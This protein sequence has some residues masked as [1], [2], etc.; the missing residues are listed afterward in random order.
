MARLTLPAVLSSVDRVRS[1]LQESLAPLEPR[2]DDFFKIEL[3]VVEL[4]VNIS[5]Y[6]YPDGA[7][8]ME[9]EIETR[10]PDGDGHDHRRGD[11]LRSPL[12]PQARRELDPGHGPDGRAGHLPGPDP[13]G[14]VRLPAR[15]RP[16]RPH[17][18]QALL[19]SI[20]RFGFPVR[21]DQALHFLDDQV[22]ALDAGRDL[23][24]G[25][26]FADGFADRGVAS[27]LRSFSTNARGSLS[28]NLSPSFPPLR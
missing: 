1:F 16:E 12:G 7:G 23:V 28:M 9:I 25:Q 22:A 2:E 21:L 15:G 18:R 26:V 10:R 20:K 14:P 6:S 17:P 24:F 3:A 8:E 19:I 4:C 13:D 5:R 11:P 27:S